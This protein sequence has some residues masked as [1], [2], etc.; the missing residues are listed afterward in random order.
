MKRSSGIGS[1]KAEVFS[2]A[3]DLLMVVRRDA[4]A[5]AL[6]R[7]WILLAWSR[8]EAVTEMK[9]P[10]SNPYA[11]G[12]FLAVSTLQNYVR[13]LYAEMDVR[14]APEAVARGI[15]LGYIPCCESDCHGRR[16][17]DHA[18]GASDVLRHA[19]R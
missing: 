1:A 16:T 15:Q 3:E 5:W 6:Y 12:K 13:E 8:G 10:T 7:R 9:I 14:N 17:G 11:R 4:E 18:T 2:N 19:Q